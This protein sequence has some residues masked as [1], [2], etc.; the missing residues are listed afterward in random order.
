MEA[1]RA[2]I[3]R[4]EGGLAALMG[5]AR[6]WRRTSSG[7]VRRAH[8]WL[9]LFLALLLVAPAAPPDAAAQVGV[10]PALFGIAGH[11]WWLDPHFDQF[12]MLYRDLGVTGVRVAVDW[13]QFE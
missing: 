1:M 11:A 5:A 2:A 9:L 10:P 8:G 13:K 6:L 7:R 12:L 4:T 3:R